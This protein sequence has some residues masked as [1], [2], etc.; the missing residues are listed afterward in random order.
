VEASIGGREVA[1]GVGKPRALFALLALH[2]GEAVSAD[3]LIDGIWGERPPATA[4]K[5]LQVY[6]SQ[7][8]KALAVAGG[9]GAIVTRGHG[10]ELRLG[11]DDCDAL[12]FEALATYRQLG[13]R[14][15]ADK[16]DAT[17]SGL[18][19]AGRSGP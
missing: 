3:R 6:V 16:A 7:L 13:M 5:M 17:Q 19:G 8:R 18:R 12:R 14:D 1:L 2:A 9:D 4:A 15:W 11:G 10:Y